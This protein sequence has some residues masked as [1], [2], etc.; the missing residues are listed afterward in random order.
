MKLITIAATCFLSSTLTNL[1]GQDTVP[2]SD[3]RWIIKAQASLQEGYKGYNSLYLQNGMAW[4]KDE[5]FSDGII[6]FDMYLSQR[7]SFSGMIFRMKDPAN[8]EELYLRSHLSGYPDAFQYTPVFNGDPAWQLY[9]DQHDGI[10]D[11]FVHWKQRGINMGYNTVAQYPYDRWLHVKIM[12]RGKQ[13][14]LYLDHAETPVAFIRELLMD[15]QT[16][17][18]GVKAQIGAVWFANFSYTK[19]SDIRFITKPDGYTISTPAGTIRNWQVSETFKEDKLS[20]MDRLDASWM[21][22]LNWGSLNTEATGLVNLSRISTVTDSNTVLAKFTVISDR[23]QVKRIDIG[24]SDRVKVFLNGNAL[25]SGNA[26]FR[27]RD[28][29]YLGTIGYFDALY[30]PLK[31]GENTIVMAVSETFGG[32]GIMAKWESAE[33]IH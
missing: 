11:G 33:G 9:H 27:T 3:N 25:Y 6:E 29:R 21:K 23:E 22:L 14:E 24:Y 26:S 1:N 5:Q 32:W 17:M 30:L 16:G 19:T 10:N 13:A 15:Q 4:L 31:K 2:F 8:Y 12:I 7:V 28:Y 18:I 20:G